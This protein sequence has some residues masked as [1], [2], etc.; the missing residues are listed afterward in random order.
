[1]SEKSETDILQAPNASTPINILPS[2]PPS[3]KERSWLIFAIPATFAI[4]INVLIFVFLLSLG[5]TFF[6]QYSP[7]DFFFGTTW[8]SQ[9]NVFGFLPMVYGTFV[10]VLIA[11]LIAVPLGFGV[12]I[13][14]SEIATP[15]LRSGIKVIIELLAGVP[16]IVY[17]LMGM[18]YVV[19]FVGQVFGGRSGWNG[20]SGGLVLSIMILPMIVTL[21]DDALRG[22]PKE[23]KEAGYALGSTKWQ[24]IHKVSLPLASP[25]MFTAIILAISRAFGETIVVLIITGNA[26]VIPNPFWDFTQ[27]IRTMTANIVAEMGDATIGSEQYNAML[28]SGLILFCVTFVFNYVGSLYQRRMTKKYAAFKTST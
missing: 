1:V 24:V 9:L 20:I 19:P 23:L 22:V 16:S 10:V 15:R 27:S 4:L 17:A 18:W 6:T 26:P 21:S 2:K 11:T 28:V 13:F 5:V 7:I 25:G 3:I 12:S 8:N 14:V